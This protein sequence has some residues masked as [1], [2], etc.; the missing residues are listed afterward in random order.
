MVSQFVEDQPAARI[1]CCGRRGGH[2]WPLRLMVG[3]D[4]DGSLFERLRHLTCL[5]PSCVRA[6]AGPR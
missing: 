2:D 5:P 1:P 3:N 4:S 6:N